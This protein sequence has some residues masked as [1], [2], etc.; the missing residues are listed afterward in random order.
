MII[1]INIDKIIFINTT[2]IN[3]RICYIN[4]HKKIIQKLSWRKQLP[5]FLSVAFSAA[6]FRSSVHFFRFKKKLSFAYSGWL[7]GKIILGIEKFSFEYLSKKLQELLY[8][9]WHT[10]AGKQT[11]ISQSL[12]FLFFFVAIPDVTWLLAHPFPFLPSV[13]LNYDT[14]VD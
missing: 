7:F 5:L 4:E 2:V 3:R 13:S 1:F 10:K 9:T 11:E 14:Q 12:K 8:K 6:S